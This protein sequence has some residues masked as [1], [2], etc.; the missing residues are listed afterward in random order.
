MTCRP[1][2]SRSHGHASNDP[3]VFTAEYGGTL[4]TLST[5]TITGYAINFV[6]TPATD[7]ISVDTTSGPATPIVTT[8]SGS[9]MLR[10]IVPQLIPINVTASFA[11]SGL[12]LQAA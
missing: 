6:A 9:G 7:T 8:S 12:T 4:P 5:G 10:K 1:L 2:H 3:Y 11:A